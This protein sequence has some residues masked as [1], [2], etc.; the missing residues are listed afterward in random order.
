MALAST[1]IKVLKGSQDDPVTNSELVP[2]DLQGLLEIL[3]TRF[4]VVHKI[5]KVI[6]FETNLVHKKRMMGS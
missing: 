1:D 6:M 5:L 3:K 2:P 4:E